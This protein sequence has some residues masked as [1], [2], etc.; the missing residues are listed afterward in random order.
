VASHYCTALSKPEEAVVVTKCYIKHDIGKHYLPSNHATF[1]ISGISFSKTCFNWLQLTP[2]L[3]TKYKTKQ[4]T[5]NFHGG[6][7]KEQKHKDERS[8]PV[9]YQLL[10]LPV[11]LLFKCMQELPSKVK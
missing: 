11:G 9:E 8:E 6:M 3:A 5:V 7:I 1:S 10:G 2:S 4:S